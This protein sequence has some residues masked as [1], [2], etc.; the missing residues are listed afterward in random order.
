MLIGTEN[1]AWGDDEKVG[2]KVR[3][4]SVVKRNS[5]ES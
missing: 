1:G 2:R 3:N 5:W 4:W